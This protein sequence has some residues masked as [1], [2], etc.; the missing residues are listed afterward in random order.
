MN[1]KLSVIVTAY[2]LEEYIEACIDSVLQQDYDDMEIIIIDDGST[3]NTPFLCDKY[4]EKHN[5]VK[6]V[7]KKNEGVVSALSI[8]IE[9]ANGDYI[10][11]VDGDDW[12][13]ENTYGCLM[14]RVI[15]S[16]LDILSFGAIRYRDENDCFNTHDLFEE[17]IYSGNELISIKSNML[18]NL[19][20][21]TFQI[22]PSLCMKIFVK[23]VIRKSIR[24]VRDI[25]VSYAQDVL[26]TYPAIKR[27]N[28]LCIVHN[29]YYFHRRRAVGNQPRYFTDKQY[30]A[31][32]LLVYNFLSDVFSDDK[33]FLRQLEAFYQYSVKLKCLD[34]EEQIITDKWLFPFDKVEKGS[35]VVIYGY[36]KVGKTYIQQ[37]SKLFFCNVVCIVDTAYEMYQRSRERIFP[38]EY[39]KHIEYDYIVI[40]N[41]S[42]EIKCE[43]KK[44]LIADYNIQDVKII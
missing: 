36:G 19:Q 17:G 37:L 3:D 14:K 16:Q 12:V 9:Y 29:A 2:N 21:Q 42:S 30:Y 31:K 5:K 26:I 20:K 41:A 4:E 7:H 34:N 43:I 22:D 39:I 6:V 25:K 18:W 38:V 11:F 40:A 13:K 24:D 1:Q 23:D 35:N 27:A 32:L 28:K 15:D 10:T 33:D 44:K 8:G